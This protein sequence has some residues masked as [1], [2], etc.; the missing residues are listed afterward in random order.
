MR[1]GGGQGPG[2][3]DPLLGA[4]PGP[5][6]GAEA[7]G[8]GLRCRCR[9]GRPGAVRSLETDAWAPWERGARTARDPGRGGVRARG[10]KK[11]EGRGRG[12]D[13]LGDR[14]YVALGRRCGGSPTWPYGRS[15]QPSVL[16]PAVLEPHLEGQRGHSG[17]K[18]A[19]QGH[20]PAG[21]RVGRSGDTGSPI[22]LPSPPGPI[23]GLLGCRGQWGGAWTPRRTA[24]REGP[25]P[26]GLPFTE[27]LSSGA[28]RG[29]GAQS[30]WGQVGW[31]VPHRA[32]AAWGPALSPLRGPLASCEPGSTQTSGSSSPLQPGRVQREDT[33]PSQW[34][35]STVGAQGAGL[36]STWCSSKLSLAARA[37][38]SL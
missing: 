5:R 21:P 34:I 13:T 2:S 7:G 36:T 37:T 28:T 19:R 11:D 38:R 6:G 12:G 31:F 3:R 20:L 22:A 32:E 27:A 9:E 1:P 33:P 14:G 4:Q 26:G 10:G 23:Q 35:L 16:G 8:R 29:G 15:L 17:G 30:G 25:P 18:R 24:A